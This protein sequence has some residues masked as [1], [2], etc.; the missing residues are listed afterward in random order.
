MAVEKQPPEAVPAEP[1]GMAALF[2]GKDL[3]GWDG[4]PRLWSVKDGVI[5]GETTNEVPATGNTFLILKDRKP[6]HFDLRF[7]FR[8]SAANQSG[9]QYRSSHVTEGEPANA[10]VVRG[11]RCEL[12]NENKFP[13]ASGS[14][15]DEGGKRGRLCPAGEMAVLDDDGKR[16]VATLLDAA[17]YGKL[18]KPNDWNEVIIIAENCHL[19][20]F[21]N[22]TQILDFIDNDPEKWCSPGVIALQLSAGKPMWVEFKNLSL[23]EFPQVYCTGFVARPGS[24]VFSPGM[25]IADA[26]AK[27]GGYGNCA[28]CE[29]FPGHPTYRRPPKLRRGKTEI[30]LPRESRDEWLRTELQPDDFLAFNHILF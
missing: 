4:D 17:E 22:G 28:S 9:V 12:R 29:P 18:F 23:K 15:N 1:P 26:L 8:C 14:L 2:N 16:T 3:T 5:R 21:L 19:R 30:P 6:C 7:A 25:T 27:V 10:W 11:Y 13:N 24:I 20:H